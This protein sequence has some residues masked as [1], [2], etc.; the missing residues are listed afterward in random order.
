MTAKR[1]IE[2]G[3][4]KL[5]D[6]LSETDGPRPEILVQRIDSMSVCCHPLVLDVWRVDKRGAL[7]Q[8]LSFPRGHAE[9]GPGVRWSFLNHFEFE[10]DRVVVTRVFPVDGKRYELVYDR[11]LRRYRPTTATAKLLVEEKRAP[12]E[13]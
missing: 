2:R 11:S 9:V 6:V 13:P 8:V 5:A 7:S 1:V 12:T 4:P 10:S 3:Q